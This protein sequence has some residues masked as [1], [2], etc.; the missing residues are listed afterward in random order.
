MSRSSIKLEFGQEQHMIR[1]T[2]L[3]QFAEYHNLQSK[4]RFASIVFDG[5][6]GGKPHEQ[7][8]RSIGN[9][10]HKSVQKEGETYGVFLLKSTDEKKKSDPHFFCPS[11]TCFHSSGEEGRFFV[12]I[13]QWTDTGFQ[14]HDKW[15][16]G[17]ERV[18]GFV[19]CTTCS[20]KA[21][22]RHKWP[23]NYYP[24]TEEEE[25]AWKEADQKAKDQ[26]RTKELKV[27]SGGVRKTTA[28]G[29]SKI[30]GRP[31][32][33]N[34]YNLIEGLHV[35]IDAR[36]SVLAVFQEDVAANVAAAAQTHMHATSATRA[37]SPLAA[38]CLSSR[39]FQSLPVSVEQ[40]LLRL[41]N[42]AA[43]ALSKGISTCIP[44]HQKEK[45]EET[46]A[47]TDCHPSV[48]PTSF[49]RNYL[50][51]VAV[52]TQRAAPG[53]EDAVMVTGGERF[54]DPS[55]EIPDACQT[56]SSLSSSD[57]VP[58]PF[59]P[60]SV[61]FPFD[62][63]PQQSEVPAASCSCSACSQHMP[64]G[65]TPST[66][67]FEEAASGQG[68]NEG[69]GED[70]D[71]PPLP[72][73]G[74]FGS[75]FNF[76]FGGFGR[77]GR[78]ATV[79]SYAAGVMVPGCGSVLHGED[80]GLGGM[81]DDRLSFSGVGLGFKLVSGG[82]MESGSFH[83]SSPF[84]QQPLYRAVSGSGGMF[85]LDD[86]INGR[87]IDRQLSP[88]PP[89][90]GHA[91]GPVLS[92]NVSFSLTFRAECQSPYGEPVD[93]LTGS[94]E[95]VERGVKRGWSDS[96]DE[97]EVGGGLGMVGGRKRARFEGEAEEEG[98]VLPL[99]HEHG[100]AFGLPPLEG[101][102]GLGEGSLMW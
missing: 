73:S 49:P 4:G 39:S 92:R 7:E 94:G 72:P 5:K 78:S 26:R 25:K 23:E 48:D 17:R 76:E 40:S 36:W 61:P 89:L 46:E 53:S 64:D 33:H 1:G 80:G 59:K 66:V 90:F 22:Y 56:P 71:A 81:D 18:Q 11:H 29:R 102:M 37:L 67:P 12:K 96:D 41:M 14:L 10:M 45:E 70:E 47:G 85:E 35:F 30:A 97:G 6:T 20:W 95:Y 52:P 54:V 13:W 8:V 16:Q 15:A 84:Q 51:S 32:D 55:E 60:S 99:P 3:G 100:G 69:E 82:G 88:M 28:G 101:A 65:E 27:V 86:P 44:P 87:G 77:E 93:S 24:P 50:Q 31:Y 2:V 79:D 83:F 91:G 9:I 42:A 75:L 34:I 68:G 63:V 62:V 74:P 19:P 57:S 58:S 21:M 98:G 38:G 43:D